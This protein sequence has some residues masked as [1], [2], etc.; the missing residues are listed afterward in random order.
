MVFMTIPRKGVPP[1]GAAVGQPDPDIFFTAAINGCSVFFQG[2]AQ[3][4]TVYHCGG[5]PDYRPHPKMAKVNG[6]K[7]A[8]RDPNEA[9]EFWR[10]LVLAHGDL[11][12]GEVGGEVN[13]TQYIMDTPTADASEKRTANSDAYFKW[14]KKNKLAD[15]DKFRIVEVRPWGCVFGVRTGDDWQF[16]LQENATITYTSVRTTSKLGGLSKTRVDVDTYEVARPMYVR[17]VWPNS[18]GAV[19]MTHPVAL[20]LL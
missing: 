9:A 20:E 5:D 1:V 11:T 12:K 10:A 4:P 13:K 6:F 18:G 15:K 16:Y 7:K 8:V 19:K 3:N 2:T 17:E 14:L